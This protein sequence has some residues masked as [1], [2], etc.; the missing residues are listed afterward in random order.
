VTHDIHSAFV[1]GNRFAILDSGVT[2][3][4]GT[5]EELENSSDG[6]VRKYI[7]SSLSTSRART[8]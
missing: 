4:N 1:V 3:I 5:R 8:T 2:L 7:S 6:E